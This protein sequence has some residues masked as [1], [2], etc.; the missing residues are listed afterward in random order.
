MDI[1]VIGQSMHVGEFTFE[2]TTTAANTKVVRIGFT[3]VDLDIG[4]AGASISFQDIS[5]ALLITPQGIAGKLT[6]RP[7]A[8][9]PG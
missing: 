9:L 1:V 3:D 4:A 8:S 6:G 5:G 2:Q 7:T